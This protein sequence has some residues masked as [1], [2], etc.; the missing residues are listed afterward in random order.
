VEDL[1]ADH[2]NDMNPERSAAVFRLFA[3][4]HAYEMGFTASC[5]TRIRFLMLS[6]IDCS[7][8]SR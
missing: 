4:G 7:R 8:S 3:A 1:F 5:Q 6:A 2:V